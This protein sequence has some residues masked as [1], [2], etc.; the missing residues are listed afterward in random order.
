MEN[1]FKIDICLLKGKDQE[2]KT[3]GKGVILFLDDLLYL[4][5]EPDKLISYNSWIGGDCKAFLSKEGS[6][7]TLLSNW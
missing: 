3:I 2:V 4:L 6:K 7:I 1:L 5:G